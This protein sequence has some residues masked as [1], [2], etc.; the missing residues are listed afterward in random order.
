MTVGSYR[1][2]F[3]VLL[4]RNFP[5]LDEAENKFVYLH[6]GIDKTSL[7]LQHGLKPHGHFPSIQVIKDYGNFPKVECYAGQMNQLFI[8]FIINAIDIITYEI[9]EI[10]KL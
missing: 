7:I 6:E 9:E 10:K 5:R 3:I 2:R 8:N 4:L 1:I